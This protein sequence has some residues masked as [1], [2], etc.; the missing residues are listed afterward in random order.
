MIRLTSPTGTLVRILF[1]LIATCQAQQTF[2]NAPPSFATD[3]PS[4]P[5]GGAPSSPTGYPES[6]GG[7]PGFANY[8]F[9]LI[10]ILAVLIVIAWLV[11][12]RTRRRNMARRGVRP[13]GTTGSEGQTWAGRHWRMAA[14]RES[15]RE[16][17]LDER[18]EAPPPYIPGEPAPVHDV[19]GDGHNGIALQDYHGKPPDYDAHGSSD[20]DL[21]LTR[22]PPTHPPNGQ[23]QHNWTRH[24][25]GRT[26]SSEPR[27]LPT[28]AG[29]GRGDLEAGDTAG[30][31]SARRASSEVHDGVIR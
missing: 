10:G 1:L 27:T 8:Y 17:G 12:R 9:V 24:L 23:H 16:E 6:A 20:E 30:E 7:T 19:A 13:D 18:G 31:P 26:D 14:V 15:R 21:D 3:I 2:G 5:G 4:P 25:L 22:P 11:A 28:I 29:T